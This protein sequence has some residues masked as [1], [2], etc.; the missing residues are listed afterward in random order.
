M[1]PEVLQIPFNGFTYDS[2]TFQAQR[3]A[4]TRMNSAAGKIQP[5][6]PPVCI[7]LPEKCI[8]PTI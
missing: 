5:S 4:P 6:Y 8:S 3:N 1:L 7:G 2:R